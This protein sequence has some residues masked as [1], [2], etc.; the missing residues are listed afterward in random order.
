MDLNILNWVKRFNSKDT[1]T[2]MMEQYLN[3]ISQLFPLD[4]NSLFS[5]MLP[6][7]ATFYHYLTTND[8]SQQQNLHEI[9]SFF[10]KVTFAIKDISEEEEFFS[11]IDLSRFTQILVANLIGED[12]RILDYSFEILI[13]LSFHQNKQ[14]KKALEENKLVQA[15]EHLLNSDV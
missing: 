2:L 4:E 11:E 1:G 15:I 10:A 9:L 13:Y 5:L 14:I 6:Y 7:V 12:L 8:F 3:F